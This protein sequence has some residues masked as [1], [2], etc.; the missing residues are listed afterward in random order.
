MAEDA[1][2]IKKSV[3]VVTGAASGIGLA[4]AHRLASRHALVL[5]DI[6]GSKLEQAAAALTADGAEA[7]AVAMDVTD[8]E[9]VAALAETVRDLGRFAALVNAAGIS[10]TMGTGH[11]IIEV[12][13]LGAVLIERALLELAE[14]GSA[15]VLIASNSGHLSAAA[16]A[17]AEALSE[18]DSPDLFDRLGADGSTPETAYALS[19]LGVIRHCAKVAPEWA[20]RGARI[21]S[22]SP[23][24]IDT[25]MGQREFARQPL[26][27]PMLDMTPLGRRGRPEDIAA[28]AAFL[29]SDEASFITGTD[30][31]VDGGITPL[32]KSFVR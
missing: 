31:L 10:P 28:M 3:A 13:L 9:A 19:K 27:K 12:N 26:M 14:P 21:V 32:F 20:K 18:P 30:F 6:D 17:H 29:L 15:A 23:G 8:H 25:P 2:M 5:T 1:G 11:R 24:M 16:Q 4:C 7:V 22:I